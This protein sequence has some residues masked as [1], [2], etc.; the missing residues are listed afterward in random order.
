M[1]SLNIVI[2][3]EVDHG[4]S[5]L[6]GRMIYDTKSFPDDRVR[7]IMGTA[8]KNEFAHF[9]D[10]F[11]EEREQEMTVDT[12]QVAIKNNGKTYT[13][14]DSPGHKEFMRNMITGAAYANAAVVVCDIKEGLRGQT[15]RHAY[16]LSLMGIK[17]F[18]VVI[19]KMDT[20][21]Y[22]HAPFV[23]L[24]RT[25][26]DF[27]KGFGIIPLMFIPASA[28][29][30][31][32]IIKRSLKM[33]WYK[34]RA[35]LE[36]FE[37][38]DPE[39]AKQN[40]GTLFSVQDTLPYKNRIMAVGRVEAG[41]LRTHDSVSL[42]PSG[43][44]V[45]IGAIKRFLE[46]DRPAKKGDC[47]GIILKEDMRLKRGDILSDDRYPS[48]IVKDLTAYVLV[49]AE[50]INK[51]DPFLLRCSTQE[52]AAG[53]SSIQ[54]RRDSS[55]LEEIDKNTNVLNYLDA[56]RVTIH[57]SAPTAVKTIGESE[58]LS[59]FVLLQNNKMCAAGVILG[60]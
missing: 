10:S 38:L 12:T 44:K 43:R 22:Q 39:S 37:C 54:E 13:I 18:I 26:A 41:L 7:E 57:L 6:I 27:F 25:A 50:K 47:V 59:R 32:N 1:A 40:E 2:T 9:L 60:Y 51:E 14:I 17:K 36:S 29:H 28:L 35:L 49:F 8:G 3:G 15:K 53:I 31:E 52:I 42:S 33:P 45:R 58:A 34:G 46:K 56:A 19:N 55:S 4:K 48:A 21:D 16:V 24:Q 23:E 11:R 5:T 30:G 20:V